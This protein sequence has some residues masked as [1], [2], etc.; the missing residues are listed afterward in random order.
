MNLLIY[1]N[2][3]EI[4]ILLNFSKVHH[5]SSSDSTFCPK[6]W[7][8]CFYLDLFESQPSICSIASSFQDIDLENNELL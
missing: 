7:Q 8:N 5:I 6:V 3:T 1:I 4:I 2:N